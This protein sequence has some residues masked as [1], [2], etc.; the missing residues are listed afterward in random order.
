MENDVTD[1]MYYFLYQMMFE[2]LQTENVYEGLK[3]S[4]DLLKVYLNCDDIILHKKDESG[5]YNTYLN[6]SI[7]S[8][9]IVQIECIV[10]KTAYLVENKT[11]QYLDLN[12][13]D[14]FQKIVL[15]SIPT[16]DN[17][18]I[19]S[20]N[21]IKRK[22]PITD[23]QLEMF[24]KT[25][26]I[27]LK[28]ADIH[29]KNIR[30]INEDTLTGLK[31]RTSYENDIKIIDTSR[32]DIIYGLFDIFRLKY[33]NDNYSHAIGDEYIIK[34]GKILNKYWPEY[35]TEVNKNGLHKTSLTGNHVYKIGGDEFALITTSEELEL[36]M[37]KAKLAA[38]EASMIKLDIEDDIP[39]GLNFG[40]VK[41]IPQDTIK[42]SYIRADSL[43]QNDKAM[44]YKKLNLERRKQNIN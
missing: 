24:L 27:I 9:Y 11:I 6:Q 18:Y 33:I 17:K 8:N 34:I 39:V 2:A 5:N 15:T 23:M 22:E 20:I 29:E 12:L 42:D 31:N 14:K 7:D 13:S 40:I 36:A 1:K 37:I 25:M 4:F 10:N 16:D 28:R 30:T 32:D 21:N 44:L 35:N 38:E 43:M 26:Q 19:L 41:H 3:K